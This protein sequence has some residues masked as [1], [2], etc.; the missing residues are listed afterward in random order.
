MT[1]MP[2]LI[3]GLPNLNGSEDRVASAMARPG[4]VYLPAG[5][6]ELRTPLSKAAPAQATPDMR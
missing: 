2:E 3:D 1:R 5:G 6:G 4:P